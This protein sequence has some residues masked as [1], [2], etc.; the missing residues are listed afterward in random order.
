MKSPI[1]PT[2]FLFDNGSLRAASTLNLRVVAKALEAEI[3]APVKA[4]SLLHSS[5]VDAAELGGVRA[6][7]LE[8]ALQ[9]WL[10]AGAEREAV[11]LPFFFG[12]SGALTEYLPERLAAV[13]A[14]F[15]E[16][17]LG[18][19]GWLVDLESAARDERV[20]GA[21]VEAVRATIRERRLMKPK[22][23]VVDHGSPQRGVAAVRDHLAAQVGRMLVGEVEVVG[24]ASMERRPGEQ[25]A[26]NDPLLAERL[27]TAPFDAGDVVLALQ[28]LSPGRHAGAGGDVAEICEAAKAER[29]GLRTWM[30]GTIGADARVI[31]VLAERYREAAT[32]LGGRRG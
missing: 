10:A 17:R 4:V 22:V 9:E 31:S 16:A 27:K 24:A 14:K 11:V 28:F 29:A 25:Y 32:R 3:G 5:G 15:P 6:E 8:P 20:A 13:R 19:A 2:C 18:Q 30:T 7:L 23:V 26:F 12:P 21:V 1:L